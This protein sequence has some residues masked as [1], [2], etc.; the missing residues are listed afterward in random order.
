[1]TPLCL[2]AHTTVHPGFAHATF[3]FELVRLPR[4]AYP[5]R[6]NKLRPFYLAATV[7][8]KEARKV[9]SL[10][11]AGTTPRRPSQKSSKSQN[12]RPR[13][14]GQR[15]GIRSVDIR[16]NIKSE[17]ITI[18]LSKVA[19]AGKKRLLLSF[20]T[21]V[22]D[23]SYQESNLQGGIQLTEWAVLAKLSALYRLDS[24]DHWTVDAGGFGTVVALSATQPASARFL[25]ASAHLGYA[26]PLVR[27]P[28]RLQLLGG[29]YF[30]TMLNSPN[31]FGFS[32]MNGLQISPVLSRQF[33]LRNRASLY[34]K[35]SPVNF[36]VFTFSSC[37]TAGGGAFEWGT[38]SGHAFALTLDVARLQLA[39]PAF[40]YAMTST[41]VT[42]G[43]VF[44]L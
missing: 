42:L 23:F 28:W 39:I 31:T 29:G 8:A 20:G 9:N 7:I 34:F 18:A 13:R 11:V 3:D 24:L 2:T 22:S 32:N 5:D 35:Y 40:Q 44:T 36:S 1:M 16:G 41:A 12:L 4:R 43:V 10:G 6:P 25:G 26:I 33:G 17:T 15:V 21:G 19:E 30:L 38:L 27:A 37:E 14:C